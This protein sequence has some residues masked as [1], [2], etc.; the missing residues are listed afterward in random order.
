M[1]RR[2]GQK[3]ADELVAWIF[4]EVLRGQPAGAVPVAIDG[5]LHDLDLL[6]L[7]ARQLPS[8]RRCGAGQR[9]GLGYVALPPRFPG[10]GGQGHQRDRVMSCHACECRSTGC[11]TAVARL[12]ARLA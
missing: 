9:P 7:P 12:S 5:Q 8:C 4:C 3:G 6:A 2:R 10:P 1:G 11:T